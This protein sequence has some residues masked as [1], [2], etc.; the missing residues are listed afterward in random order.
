MSYIQY[1]KMNAANRQHDLMDPYFSIG[2][3]AGDTRPAQD[4]HADLQK[5]LN[6]L[7][8]YLRTKANTRY[9]VFRNQAKAH[10]K[11]AV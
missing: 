6:W 10:R 1:K 11:H 9:G 5:Q 4:D 2:P 8:G 3:D 7:G